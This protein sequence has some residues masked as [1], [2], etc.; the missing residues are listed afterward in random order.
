MH[1]STKRLTFALVVIHHVMIDRR[2]GISIAVG[3]IGDEVGM[4]SF[5]QRPTDV[6]LA[7]MAWEPSVTKPQRLLR[8]S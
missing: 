2:V 1:Q 3:L 4:S 7:A 5:I 8:I 6:E